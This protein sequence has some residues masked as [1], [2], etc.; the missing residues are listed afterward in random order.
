[1]AA[2]LPNASDEDPIPVNPS[3]TMTSSEAP[4]SVSA[5]RRVMTALEIDRGHATAE[6]AAHCVDRAGGR[7]GTGPRSPNPRV[8]EGHDQTW[9]DARPAVL[10]VRIAADDA[11]GGCLAACSNRNN[12]SVA[13]GKAPAGVSA[14]V[15]STA[16]RAEARSLRRRGSHYG[17]GW[18]KLWCGGRTSTHAGMLV[19]VA[20]RTSS[21]AV[22]TAKATA[23]TWI[24]KWSRVRVRVWLSVASHYNAASWTIAIVTEC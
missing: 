16:R 5:E 3:R 4:G 22:P 2:V 13:D 17:W 12:L 21:F 11:V 6:L 20:I 18:K 7:G 24:L 9:Q 10:A 15:T 19:T 8:A 14:I 1:M 23:W